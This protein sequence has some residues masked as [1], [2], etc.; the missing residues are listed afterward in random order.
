LLLWQVLYHYGEHDGVI[1][2]KNGFQKGEESDD[3]NVL[4][5]NHCRRSLTKENQA[6][7]SS[8]IYIFI[9]RLFS[10]S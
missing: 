1:Y 9:R 6:S 3:K 4:K 10:C 5:G 7:I 2:G 8:E